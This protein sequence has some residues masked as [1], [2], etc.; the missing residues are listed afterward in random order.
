MNGTQIT[1]YPMVKVKVLE[2]IHKLPVGKVCHSQS[3]TT[4]ADKPFIHSKFNSFG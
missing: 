3:K 4:A 2:F 1:N